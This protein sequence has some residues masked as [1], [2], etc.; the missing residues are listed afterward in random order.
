MAIPSCCN[1]SGRRCSPVNELVTDGIPVAATCRAPKLARSPDRPKRV[2]VEARK[3][4]QVLHPY[5]MVGTICRG[6]AASTARPTSFLARCRRTSWTAALGTKNN[7]ASPIIVTWIERAYYRSR[8][9]AVQSRLT[10]VAFEA[11]MATP[12]SQAA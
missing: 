4:I 12:A 11:I 3:F 7:C 2:G 8:H 1:L 9:Q 5:D 6:D 10:P